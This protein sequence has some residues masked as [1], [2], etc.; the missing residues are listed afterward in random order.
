[1]G[2]AADGAAAAAAGGGGDL[3]AG[4]PTYVQYAQRPE[5]LLSLRACLTCRLV[6]TLNQFQDAFCDNCWRDW[7]DGSTP[8]SL[9]KGR[10]LDLALENTTADYE[11]L[12]S[13]MR[14]SDSWV[15]KWLKM[16]AC[17]GLQLGCPLPCFPPRLAQCIKVLGTPHGLTHPTHHNPIS[18]PTHPT[19]PPPLSLCPDRI[20][21]DGQKQVL[22]PGV[23]AI[24]L[25]GVKSRAAAEAAAED[26]EG[27]EGEE[28][29]AGGMEEE[30]S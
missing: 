27:E 14:P 16:S 17:P 12:T 24:S 19:P 5:S 9:K 1:M 30:E 23:Y 22:L 10:C 8:G 13:Q 6:K 20:G 4:A 28:E 11:G 26:Y 29:G 25:P 15:G 7:A 18:L 2:D 3:D 21:E